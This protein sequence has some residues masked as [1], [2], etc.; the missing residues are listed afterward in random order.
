LL[1]LGC[2]DNWCCWCSN[3]RVA[4]AAVAMAVGCRWLAMVVVV[5]VLLH[6]VVDAAA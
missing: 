2:Y 5:V 3:G 6:V 1:L 4:I